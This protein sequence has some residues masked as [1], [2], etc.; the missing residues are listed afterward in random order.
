MRIV[1]ILICI[2]AKCYRLTDCD[3]FFSIGIFVCLCYTFNLF[4]IVTTRYYINIFLR[5][6]RR[7]TVIICI[8]RLLIVT[9]L[10]I[11]VRCRFCLLHL[12][13]CI[14]NRIGSFGCDILY[15]ICIYVIVYCLRLYRCSVLICNLRNFISIF[16]SDLEVEVFSFFYFFHVLIFAVVSY[17]CLIAIRSPCFD[18][19]TV[20]IG[21]LDRDMISLLLR[22]LLYRLCTWGC[23]GILI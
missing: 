21:F 15:F 18:G 23:P 13:F 8:L 6:R 17:I 20:N 22:C 19:S 9:L 11:A 4:F 2:T 5:L 16:C 12:F 1:S 7:L 14:S 3:P 10:L